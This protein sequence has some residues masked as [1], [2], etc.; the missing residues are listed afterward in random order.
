MELL[1]QNTNQNNYYRL[2]L[3]FFK[4]IIFHSNLQI[5]LYKIKLNIAFAL[6]LLDVYLICI[7]KFYTL[8]RILMEAN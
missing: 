5:F 4:H 8:I 1:K 3:K 7:L 6:F 2:F